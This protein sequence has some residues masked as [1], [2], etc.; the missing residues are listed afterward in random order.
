MMEAF[1]IVFCGYSYHCMDNIVKCVLWL[2]L[3]SA[4]SNGNQWFEVW[5]FARVLDL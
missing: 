5:S 1:K 4:V 2:M 3:V